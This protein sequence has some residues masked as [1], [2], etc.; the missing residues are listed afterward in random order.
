MI[1]NRPGIRKRINVIGHEDELPFSMINGKNFL[2]LPDS[3]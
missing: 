2:E 3:S 1:Q